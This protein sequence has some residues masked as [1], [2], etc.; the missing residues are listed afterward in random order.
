MSENININV[1]VAAKEE[2]TKQLVYILS[3]EIYTIL[4]N[5]F[6]DSQLL[7]K[8]RSISLRNFQIS[9]KKIPLWNTL[10]IEKNNEI[11]KTKY[12]YLLDLITAIFV[13]HVKI[14][15][16][17]KLNN[18]TKS[19]DVK[20]PNLDHFLHKIIV[21]IAENIYYNPDVIL[22]KKE[23]VIN[24]ISDNIEQTIRNQ[25][26]IDKILTEYL[27]GVFED[28][29]INSNINFE[30]NNNNNSIKQNIDEDSDDE[31]SE[32]EES[33]DE[34]LSDQEINDNEEQL[35]NKNIVPTRPLPIN[36]IDND[37]IPIPYNNNNNNNN[38]N[39]ETINHDINNGQ[40][41]INKKVLFSD[42]TSKEK[43]HKTDDDDDDDDDDDEESEIDFNSD[44]E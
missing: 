32:D 43:K 17:V 6:N 12:P 35:E 27:A 20:V 25:I 4:L 31:D 30:N 44:L 7:K 29:K 1:L 42:A 2:Y 41:I 14:L 19:I 13:S 23:L 22:K 24:L 38:L 16:C 15:A 9:L 5:V 40:Q 26:P 3:P 18:D 11:I 37:S 8:K 21:T 10:I 34:E 33:E 36:Q 28:E 39:Q